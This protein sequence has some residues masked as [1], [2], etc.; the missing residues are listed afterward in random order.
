VFEWKPL[1]NNRTTVTKGTKV[2]KGTTAT[3]ENKGY[4]GNINRQC[5][6]L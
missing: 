4:T 5:N 2:T 1:K 3:K 6:S